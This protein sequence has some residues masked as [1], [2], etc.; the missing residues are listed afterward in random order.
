MWDFIPRPWDHA[1]GAQGSW[2]SHLTHGAGIV[3][4]PRHLSGSGHTYHPTHFYRQ[5]W[6]QVLLPHCAQGE[7]DFREVMSFTQ[8]LQASRWQDCT[9]SLASVLIIL[10]PLWNHIRPFL[11]LFFWRIETVTEVTWGFL[12]VHSAFLFPM[13][14]CFIESHILSLVPPPKMQQ[15]L[16]PKQQKVPGGQSQHLSR[17]RPLSSQPGIYTLCQTL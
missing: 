10:L 13:R 6:L 17:A 11:D 8:A 1:P 7:A 12:N 2:F 5:L 14:L 4:V 15:G 16:S 3:T 9:S